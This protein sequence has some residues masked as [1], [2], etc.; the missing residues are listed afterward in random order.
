M[1]LSLTNLPVSRETVNSTP[2]MVILV[3]YCTLLKLVKFCMVDAE[4]RDLRLERACRGNIAAL[5]LKDR[6]R[7]V[8]SN[9]SGIK[10]RIEG[11]KGSK[12]ET[13]D[14]GLQT[15]ALRQ[16]HVKLL[17]FA[18]PRVRTKKRLA[19]ESVFVQKNL[20]FSLEFPQTICKFLCYITIYS[21]KPVQI[22]LSSAM[23]QQYADCRLILPK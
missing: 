7:N 13:S 8:R 5:A 9:E 22:F 10:E 21:R 1:S 15:G 18:Q 17:I 11:E 2:A 6:S 20:L 4:P 3:T 12:Y 16:V 19:A 23:N 14:D